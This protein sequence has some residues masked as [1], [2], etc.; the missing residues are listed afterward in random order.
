MFEDEE[1][2]SKNNI[3]LARAACVIWGWVLCFKWSTYYSY[4]WDKG[5][6]W[7]SGLGLAGLLNCSINLLLYSNGLKGVAMDI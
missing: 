5:Y 7:L 6:F 3:L 2:D 1:Q 4:S